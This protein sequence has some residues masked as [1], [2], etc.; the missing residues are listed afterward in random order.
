MQYQ[1][2]DIYYL[3]TQR[4]FSHYFSF[5]ATEEKTWEVSSAHTLNCHEIP[6]Y[7]LYYKRM[8]LFLFQ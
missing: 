5:T 7:Y 3:M 1:S 2:W 4:S 8:S 6:D